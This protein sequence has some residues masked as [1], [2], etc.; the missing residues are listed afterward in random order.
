LIEGHV[1]VSGYYNDTARVP[2]GSIILKINSRPINE[3]INTVKNN[4]SSAAMNENFQL[5]GF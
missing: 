2:I 4:Y 1:V 5:A 3:I